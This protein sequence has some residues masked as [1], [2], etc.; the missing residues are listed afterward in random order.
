MCGI[1]GLLLDEINPA[2]PRWL[3]AMT[4]E[5]Y[6]RGP[7]DG[8][9]AAFGMNGTP[10]VRRR[11]GRAD[12]PVDW[13]Y[14][15]MKLGLGARRLAIVDLSDAGAQPMS[16]DD[17]RVWLVYNGELYNHAALR[18]ELI[19]RG[20]HFRG[21]SDTETFLAGYRSWGTDCFDRFD[22]MWAAAIVDWSAGRLVLSRDRFGIK[23][24]HLARFDHGLAFASEIKALL[25]LPGARRGVNEA[26]LRDFLCDGRVDHTGDTLFEGVWSAPPGCFIE[27]DLRAKGTMHAGG[28]L[29]RYWRPSFNEREP[30]DSTANIRDELT[31]SLK[32]HLQG[33]VPIGTCLSG[34]IDSS[35]VV[36]ILDGLRKRGAIDGARLTQHVFTASLPGSPLDESSYADA[37]VQACGG[38]QAHIV[39]PTPAGFV[40]AL[41]E[42]MHSQ[43]QPFALPGAYLQWEIM[44]AARDVGV[45]VL[46]DGQG[47]DELFCGYEGYIPAYL[48]FLFRRADMATL[49][50]EWRAARQGHFA[51]APLLRHVAG[52]SLSDALRERLRLR[53]SARRQPWLARDLFNGQ[54]S[55]DM[56]HELDITD[57]AAAAVAPPD[58]VFARRVWS[59]FAGES[60]PGLLRFEDRSS[61]AFSIE[62]RVPFLSRGMVERAFAAPASEKI[63]GGVLK[64]NLRAALR[65]IVPDVILDRKD[66]LGYSVPLG[67]WMRG[68]LSE[69]WRDL[70]ASRSLAERGC[71]NVKALPE[72]ARRVETGEMAAV[73]SVFRVAIVE[74]WARAFLDRP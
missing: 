70:L 7:D 34:G 66:K 25:T 47:G 26:R 11:L 10:A 71:F 49:L 57:D 31:T 13:K 65:G 44:Q 4:Q 74:T 41:S 73:R 30:V 43:E 32:A 23:P 18:D 3:T 72:A 69:W 36:M 62:A 22:G 45:K 39:K 35:A 6:H 17:E 63:S 15:P 60:L 46:L 37:V 58:S 33:D 9:A 48:A 14:V 2:A 20:M 19:A 40:G 51:G 1:A 5:L 42:L 53:D 55:L 38:L 56:C 16:S 59:L 52:A 27:F 12:E 29:R 68:G 54:S 24:L 21:H 50:R 8:G 61:M 67:E 28:I 64:A